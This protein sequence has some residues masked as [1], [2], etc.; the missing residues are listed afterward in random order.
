MSR[1]SQTL[2]RCF[3]FRSDESHGDGPRPIRTLKTGEGKALHAT[4]MPLVPRSIFSRARPKGPSRT[5][6]IAPHVNPRVSLTAQ[7][8]NCPT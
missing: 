1:G 8:A 2:W 6:I 4:G 5:G 3:G 7:A